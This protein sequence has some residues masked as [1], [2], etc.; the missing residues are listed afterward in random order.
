MKKRKPPFVLVTLLVVFVGV[1]VAMSN[2][3]M[4]SSG[5]KDEPLEVHTPDDG[6]G[7]G[8]EEE[9]SKP[10]TPTTDELADRAGDVLKSSAGGKD[11]MPIPNNEK[12]RGFQEN[13]IMKPETP[14][15]A[16]PKKTDSDIAT[17]WWDQK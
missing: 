11:A 16:K 7:H 5:M 17:Q 4:T 12:M 6:H 3:V 10:P 14:V 1:A 9:A 15:T 2:K 13:T 8:E